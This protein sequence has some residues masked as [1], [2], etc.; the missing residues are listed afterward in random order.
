MI[1]PWNS[2]AKA[3]NCRLLLY[4]QVNRLSQQADEDV[5]LGLG[6]PLE[7]QHTSTWT[8]KSDGRPD[9]YLSRS[10]RVMGVVNLTPDSFSDGGQFSTPE[11]GVQH[12]LRLVEEGADLLDLGAESTRPG[13][14]VYGSGSRELAPEEELDRLMPVLE[15]LR[16]RLAN[17]WISVDTRKGSVARAALKAGADMINDVGGLSDPEL[18]AAVAEAGCPVVVMHSRG[19]LA[20]MQ[21]EV[22]YEDVLSEVL[23]ELEAMVSRGVDGGIAR[24]RIIVDPG[25]GFGKLGP[26]NLALIGGLDRLAILGLPVLLGASRKSFI[27][28]ISPSDPSRRLGGSL[29][30]AA[31]GARHGAAIL[32]VHDVFETAQF[33][34]VWNGIDSASDVG[35]C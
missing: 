18:I 12:G 7:S 1:H 20:T 13:G 32:R 26:H 33:L 25:I 5:G 15:P 22:A 8:L 35:G 19:R 30:A 9:L 3:G 11:D 16:S 17:T 4:L 23:G 2:E 14:G 6:E 31:W 28:E 24:E 21:R 34:Q 29:A 10:P 27:A